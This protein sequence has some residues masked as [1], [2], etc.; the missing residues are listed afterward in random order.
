MK[1]LFVYPEKR[2]Y[3]FVQQKY[4]A[5]QRVMHKHHQVTIDLLDGPSFGQLTADAIRLCSEADIIIVHAAILISAYKSVQHWRARDKTVIA[6]LAEPIVYNEATHKYQIGVKVIPSLSGEEITPLMVD[7]NE[8][9]WLLKLVEYGLTNSRL[10]VEDWKGILEVKYLPDM[11]ELDKYLSYPYESHTGLIFGVN[12]ANG[13]M[14]KLYQTGL[15]TALEK[16]LQRH[17]EVK[18]I[19][20]GEHPHHAHLLKV[21]PERKY[22]IPS[23]EKAQ[24]QSIL[25]SIDIGLLPRMGDI[26]DRLGSESVL[27]FMAM[28]IP[29]VGS[30]SVSLF[31]QRSYGWLV[32]NQHS[33]WTKVLED[34]IEHIDNYRRD[35]DDSYLYAIGQGLDENFD[36]LISTCIQIHTQIWDGVK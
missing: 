34:L 17:K 4:S 36:R 23:L 28:K 9:T 10:V 8:F 16:V 18:V 14:P 12:I 25:P 2:H 30:E 6:D 26:D 7:D 13:G 35:T 29:W 22:F 24:W 5:L 27:E 11:L 1:I 20:Y 21:D 32:S 31:A 3:P 19:V 15:Q 33:S